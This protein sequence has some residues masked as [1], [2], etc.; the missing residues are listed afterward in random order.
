MDCIKKHSGKIFLL[1]VI[2]I[3]SF[4]GYRVAK[5]SIVSLKSS[6]I[7]TTGSIAD[8]P[9]VLQP[10]QLE[11]SLNKGDVEEITK[12]LIINHP[13]IIVQ[14]LEK[15]QQNK[16]KE[17]N[18]R[19]AAKLKEKKA[20]LE[21][22]SLVPSAG[23]DSADVKVIAFLDYSCGYCKKA[24][25]ALNEL[26][27]SDPAVQVIYYLHPVLGEGSEYLSKI[28]LI[29]HKI[30][31]DKFKSFHDQLI[32]AQISTT[33][34]IAKILEEN[35]IKFADVAKELEKNDIKVSLDRTASLANYIGLSG[36]P[37][38]IIGD[39]LYPGFLD[40]KRLKDI[41]GSLRDSSKT[42]K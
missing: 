13:E 7:S 32:N 29:V 42:S 17:Q 38:I 25:G 9:K 6:H 23:S 34:D 2:A 8:M 41:V 26:I 3:I 14:S 1:I 10:V 28:A 31:P 16:A 19:I 27:A 30:A 33:E 22:V 40:L 4:F 39:Q 21:N 37:V 5:F 11:P 35:D 36:V 15:L 18:D 20:E 12:E 24:N